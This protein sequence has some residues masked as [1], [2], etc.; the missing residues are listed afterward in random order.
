MTELTKGQ[1]MWEKAQ[2]LYQV[3][4]GMGRGRVVRLHYC[5]RQAEAQ[6]VSGFIASLRDYPDEAEL[7]IRWLRAVAKA[8]TP[9]IAYPP[10]RVERSSNGAEAPKEEVYGNPG[11]S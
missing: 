7:F 5:A 10:E 6:H 9:A 4:G 8:P 3:M 2:G 11:N 1:V